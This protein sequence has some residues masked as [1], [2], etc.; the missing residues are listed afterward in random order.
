MDI[1]ITDLTGYNFIIKLNWDIDIMKQEI[2]THYEIKLFNDFL[3]LNNMSKFEYYKNTD[4]AYK[5]LNSDLHK[6][7]ENYYFLYIQLIYKN[8]ILEQYDIESD[9]LTLDMLKNNN[10]MSFVIVKKNDLNYEI[11]DGW[12]NENN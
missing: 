11:C 1:I 10:N 5:W 9:F 12:S 7:A 2:A 8:K 3:T 6:Q 4:N